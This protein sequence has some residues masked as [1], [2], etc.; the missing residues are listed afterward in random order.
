MTMGSANSH[1]YQQQPPPSQKQQSTTKPLQS[2]NIHNINNHHQHDK[3]TNHQQLQSSSITI[4]ELDPIHIK[5]RTCDQSHSRTI[6]KWD[7][8]G[9]GGVKSLVP[10][11]SMLDPPPLL[12]E[13]VKVGGGSSAGGVA[14]SSAAAA[15]SVVKVP[16][17]TV[18]DAKKCLW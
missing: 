17:K 4:I 3:F 12:D 16:L 6:I 5:L 14:A 7:N 10:P 2:S 1:H 8:G 9:L 15:P 11:L 13:A 18:G